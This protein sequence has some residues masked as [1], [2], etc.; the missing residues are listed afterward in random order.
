MAGHR[1]T[2]LS[3]LRNIAQNYDG[4][5]FDVWGTVYDGYQVFPDVVEVFKELRDQG[6][7]IAIL[8]NSPQLPSVVA[9]RL[10]KI[11]INT[12]FHDGI[13]TSG[14]ETH[15]Q[16]SEVPT[17]ETER[18]QGPVYLTGPDRFPDTLP[19]ETAPIATSIEQASWILNAGPNH[20]P[21]LVEDYELLLVEGSKRKLPML[22][23]NP[24]K[25]VLQGS[26]RHICAGALAER[27]IALGGDVYYV[28]KPHGAVFERCQ[29][30]LEIVSSNSML[31]IGDN[32]ETDI[33][34]ANRFGCGSLLIASGV[35]G[36][37]DNENGGEIG[38]I[39]YD[40][41]GVLEDGLNAHPSYIMSK[42]R[43]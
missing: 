28:G 8:S 43:W 35:H 25:T 12:D 41:L 38:G 13:V 7:R 16:L 9:R 15:R 39:L 17:A 32:L 26:E 3:G 14:G 22:C 5:V 19:V 27:Y 11:G 6:K 24:D 36:L 40:K 4:F 21:E 1:H 37:L 33:I 31:M 20:P 42:L 34:G 10:E 30:I 23:A 2:E 29:E 18:F